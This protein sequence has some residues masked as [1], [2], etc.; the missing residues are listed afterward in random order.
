[1]LIRS[2]FAVTPQTIL[3][4]VETSMLDACSADVDRRN[5]S[6]FLK[7]QKKRFIR[8]AGLLFGETRPLNILDIGCYPGI[9]SMCCK[10]MGHRVFG[11][12][13]KKDLWAS[14][15]RWAQELGVRFVEIEKMD[16][17]PFA[18]KF[19]DVII[20][21]EVIEHLR[22]KHP[23]NVLKMLGRHLKDD[24][25]MVISTP[26]AASISK[27]ALLMAGRSVYYPVDGFYDKSNDWTHIREYTKKE[28]FEILR[29]SGLKVDS[30]RYM[31]CGFYTDSFS[32][33][34]AHWLISPLKIIPRFKVGMLLVASKQQNNRNQA[35]S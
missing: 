30:F 34:L 2:N 7:T 15:P 29:K 18:Q 25:R 26:N 31:E 32:H 28:L 11:V 9:I 21:T 6:I 3:E 22:D 12:D 24:G 4:E 14:H 8:T 33:K 17:L 27:V 20:F 5:L 35:D 16:L 23:V 19:F 13:R 1:M 10:K